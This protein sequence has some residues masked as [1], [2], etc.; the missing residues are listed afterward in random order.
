[1]RSLRNVLFT[2]VV[3]ASAASPVI[4]QHASPS[5]GEH[6]TRAPAR[7][8]N[9]RSR[10]ALLSAPTEQYSHGDPTANEQLLLEMINRARANPTAEGDRLV[11]TGDANVR[12]AYQYFNIDTALVRSQF[13]TYP[14][15]PPLAFN[16]KLIAAARRH[17]ADMVANNYQGHDGTDGSTFDQRITQAGY[18]GWTA[19]GENV[20]AYS[21][22]VWYGHVG[23]NVDWGNPQLGHRHNI[24]NFDA[25][26]KIFTEFGAGITDLQRPWQQGQV[27]PMVITEEFGR[28]SEAPFLVGVVYNDVNANGFYDVGEGLSGVKVMPSSGTYYAVTSTSGGYAIP[29]G[30]AGSSFTVTFSEGPLA[31]SYV[32]NVTITNGENYKLDLA[33][34]ATPPAV[35]TI[36]PTQGALVTVDTARFVWRR[37]GATANRYHLQ[38][39]TDSL[40]S[41]LVV[42]DTTLADT[43]RTVRSLVNGTRYFWRVQARNSEGWGEYSAVQSFRVVFLP[44]AVTLVSPAAGGRVPMSGARFVWNRPAGAVTAYT[45]ELAHDPAMA[46]IAVRD[47]TVTDTALVVPA[48]DVDRYYWRVRAK[49]E[50]GWGPYSEIRI[51]E[52]ATAGIDDEAAAPA[53]SSVRPNPSI[54]GERVDARVELGAAG[55]VAV[56]LV[57]P[58]GRVVDRLFAGAHAAGTL[59]LTVDTAELAPGTYFLRVSAAGVVRGMP[60]RVVAR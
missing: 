17:T 51:V 32:R 19:L 1:M 18:T 23:F 38:V 8:S 37:P 12:G 60:V 16:A 57:D 34:T 15:R 13:A 58:L 4:A 20:A 5:A 48:L 27:G 7:L 46:N 47:T 24:M 50:A 54:I 14:S 2:A 43:A 10:G 35:V 26:D 49:N 25:T 39:A 36:R 59:D 11:M 22:S 6:I 52:A 40:M 21:Y 44:A 33:P 41:A 55:S 9:E 53:M 3:C 28:T 29:V 45:F 56:D 31:S 42:N 30:T